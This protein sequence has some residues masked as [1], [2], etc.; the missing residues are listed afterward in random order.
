MR[1]CP[2]Q[3]V[4][5]H[6]HPS[7][8]IECANASKDVRDIH[9]SYH[10][11]EHYN[12]VRPLRRAK[13][14]LPAVGGRFAALQ[15]SGGGDG[16]SSAA[17]EADEKT[18]DGGSHGAG[19]D[20][21]DEAVS[22]LH[23]APAAAPAAEAAAAQPS[24]RREPKLTRKEQRKE[25]KRLRK[26]EKHRDAIAAAGGVDEVEAD[27]AEASKETSGGRAVIVL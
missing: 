13:E 26:A 4:H 16:A 14:P 5:Q 9:L 6:E 7:Y 11:G 8:R 3:V 15:P 24:S 17:A 1:H 21:L 12:S 23:L 27:G 20:G 2:R 10:D 25:D 22:G 18:G 19:V